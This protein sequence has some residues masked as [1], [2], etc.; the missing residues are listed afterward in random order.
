MVADDELNILHIYKR[1]K[2]DSV[3]EK[4]MS[5]FLKV[6]P[7]EE[8][9]I[10]GAALIGKRIFWI[11][12]HGTSKKGKV[13]DRRRRLFSTDIVD[14]A[15]PAL[16]DA[17]APYS[18][19]VDDL[20]DKRFEKYNLAAAAKKPP[21]T[22]GALNIEGLAATPAGELLIGFRNPLWESKALIV[23]LKNPDDVVMKGEKPNLGDFIE[24]KLDGRGVRSIERIGDSYLIVAGPIDGKGSS[25]LYRW[26]SD[27]LKDPEILKQVKL[28]GL[29]PEALFAIPGGDEVQIL[30]DDGTVDAGGGKECKDVAPASQSFRSVTVKP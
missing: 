11:S 21:K 29:N 19:L 18:K 6:D 2:P 14:G 10:E 17:G 9:D 23:P 16:R 20:S 1:G 12:S 27:P 25:D 24:I 22:E 4:D 28:T 3:A 15:V 5:A 13:Q 7:D 26:S 8:S 30:S